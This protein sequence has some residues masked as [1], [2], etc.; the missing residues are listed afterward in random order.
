MLSLLSEKKSD[1]QKVIDHFREELTTIR[2][3]RAHPAIL[4]KVMVEAYGSPTPVKGLA[5]INVP[6]PKTLQIEPWDVN[7]VKDIE[8]AIIA[9]N[10]GISPVVQGKVIRLVMPQMTEDRR[11]QLSKVVKEKT[12]AARVSLRNAR[13][14]IREQII[15][16]EKDKQ[17]GEDERFRAQDELDKMTRQFQD[18]VERLAAD[19]EKE[20]MTV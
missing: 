5:A 4:D 3:G 11:K 1:F 7:L 9:A 15:K 20:I 18:E 13:E 6:D 8:A 2:S 16:M 17:I 12:E 19:K 10:L 14:K